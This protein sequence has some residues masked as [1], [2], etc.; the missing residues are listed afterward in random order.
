MAK[1]KQKFEKGYE[2]RFNEEVFTIDEVIKHPVPMYRLKDEKDEVIVGK[3][4]ESELS[5]VQGGK[6]KA[7]RIDRIIKRRG[8]KLLVRWLGHGPKEGE[9]IDQS[10]LQCITPPST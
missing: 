6:D 2:Y 1:E 9:W 7:F 5:L 3:F 8:R 4:Y 10:Q